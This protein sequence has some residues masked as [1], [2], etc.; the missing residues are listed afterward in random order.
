MREVDYP[1]SLMNMIA[2]VVVLFSQITSS[3][4]T[5][6]NNN[7]NSN[8]RKGVITL[9]VIVAESCRKGKETIVA[10]EMAIIDFNHRTNPSFA[11]QLHVITTNQT[12]PLRAARAARQL[13]KTRK[14]QAILGPHAWEESSL[15]AEIAGEAHV[16]LLSFADP[17]PEW[18]TARWPF[19]LQSAPTQHAQMEALAAIVQSWG[20]HRVTLIYEDLDSASDGV[21]PHLSAAL[22]QVG[23]EIAH[24]LPLQP[25]PSYS[26]SSSFSEELRI[27]KG[28]SC[29]VFV[30]HASMPLAVRL[31]AGA[32]EMEMMAKDYVWITTAAT[33]NLV[34]SIDASAISSMQ[35]VVGIRS[36]FPETAQRFH[37]F[38]KRFR[39]K[40]GEDHPEEEN[41]EPGI[42]AAQAYDAAWAAAT[43][44]GET[45]TR[46]RGGEQLLET[47]SS[48]DFK[49]L[50]GEVR[51]NDRK[52]PTANVFQI[53][54]VIGRSYRELGSWSKERGFSESLDLERGDY[55]DSMAD[56]APVIWPGEPRD[57]PRGWTLPTDTRPMRVGVP[58]GSSFKEFV[59]VG[60]DVHTE[61]FSYTGFSIEIFKATI[62]RL[63]YYWPYEFLPFNGTYDD[64]VEQVYKK[65]L[66]AVAG[67]VSIVAK[68]YEHA[69]F[70]PPYTETGLVMIVPVQTESS[71]AWLFLKPFT[72][73][74][75]ALI[76]V[77]NVYNGFVVW[78]IERNHCPELKGSPLNQLGTLIWLAFTTLF[79]LHGKP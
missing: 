5:E 55:K 2:I 17:T 7:N 16:P 18:A 46:G 6:L 26:S 21:I 31:F 51:F 23:A 50:S 67:D 19:L 9:A 69:E 48:I 76:L 40:F 49:G 63:P 10:A 4:A 52:L 15:I 57:T 34:H 79:S 56:L 28:E 70:T 75:W 37:N 66:D 8:D 53:V 42:F 65:K 71:K 39:Q 74:M 3:Y 30:V 41:H 33:T 27:L 11:M 44:L 59:N 58:T 12:Q 43:A 68:R 61:N 73:A 14:V 64:L 47:L 32:K 1:M 62:N 54:N 29:K 20:W 24:L 38:S 60:F 36:Y 13:I 35:G 77:F 72:I 25:F 45:H 22:R 78:F